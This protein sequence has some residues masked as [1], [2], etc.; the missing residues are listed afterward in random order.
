[1]PVDLRDPASVRSPSQGRCFLY[2]LP[3]AY[4]DLLKVGFSRDPLQR[5]QALHRRWYEFFDPQRI[6]LVETDTVREARG[7]ELATKHRLAELNAPAPMTVVHEA[8]GHGEWYRGAGTQLEVFVQQLMVQ[9]YRVHAP[10][11]DW[12]RQA[13][14]HRLE[15][16]YSWTE[17]L[18]TVDELELR[19]GST[20][21]QRIVR[22]AL[23]AF[24]ALD[25]ALEEWLPAPVLRWYRAG[26]GLV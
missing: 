10:A 14:S 11:H 13:L 1:M 24:T 6:A 8:G 26:G 9:G 21:A 23:D 12:L 2:M 4:E 3:C 15:L 18:L 16:L 25:I 17:A 20:P 22:D 7:L 19:A 5:L